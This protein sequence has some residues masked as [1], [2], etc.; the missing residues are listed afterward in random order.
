VAHSDDGQIETVKYQVLDSMLLNEVQ[1]Q[2][3]VSG[4]QAALW[5]SGFLDWR[6]PRQTRQA[7]KELSKAKSYPAGVSKTGEG[8]EGG[9][10]QRGYGGI[11]ESRYCPYS[12]G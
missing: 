10:R 4:E 3:R 5:R 6:L 12:G 1:R 9:E 2:E 8:F 11:M 7:V